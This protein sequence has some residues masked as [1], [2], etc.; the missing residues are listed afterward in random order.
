MIGVAGCGQMGLPMAQALHAGGL[1]IRGL[2]V[3]PAAE[4]GAFAPH[5]T[6]DRAA[7]AQG[8]G[9]LLIV[10]RDIPQT[11]DVLFG[12][13]TGLARAP[14]LQTVV[15][16]ST[17]SPRYV[18]DLRDRLPNA[19]GLVDAPMSG[20]PVAAEERRLSFMVG[21]RDSDVDALMPLLRLMGTQIH[22][23][24]GPGAGMTAKV[25]NNL[26]AASSVAATRRALAWGA[27]LGMDRDTLLRIFHDSSGQTW[28]GSNFD[29]IAFA[30]EGFD[31]ANTMG[32]LEKDISSLVDALPDGAEASYPKA[33]IAAI[34]ALTPLE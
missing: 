12:S 27:E 25:L 21:G 10:V 5:M 28:F 7:F 33:L 23:V 34:R 15:I 9:T 19:V 26:I 30:R 31:R 11:E 8:L 29:R 2:D 6:T 20:A 13:D 1:D 24:G 16:C 22:H 14:D 3:R 4:F 17:V 32:I 18:Q